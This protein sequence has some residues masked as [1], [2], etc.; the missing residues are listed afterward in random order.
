MADNNN[1]L[2]YFIA[3]MGIGV[4]IGMLVAPRSGEETRKYLRERADESRDYLRTRTEEGREF[5]RRRSDELRD[6]ATEYI[7]KGRDVINR[8]KDQL[9]AAVEAGKQAY[10]ESVTDTSTIG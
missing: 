1:G 5:V 4:A 6:Q 8:Q 3:G 7:E 10:R 9:T 2:G